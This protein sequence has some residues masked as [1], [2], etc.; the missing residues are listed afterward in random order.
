MADPQPTYNER[1]VQARQQILDRVRSGR[2]ERV[3]RGIARALAQVQQEAPSGPLT[4]ETARQLRQQYEATL[5]QLRS[6]LVAATEAQRSQA[7][8][9]TADAHE[10]ALIA[11]AIAAGLFGSEEEAREQVPPIGEWA[12][13]F[14][15]RIRINIQVR[16]GLSDDMEPEA[17]IT[18]ILS[19][20]GSEI[21]SAIGAATGESGGVEEAAQRTA[22]EVARDIG[23][24]I[25]DD[26]LSEA[27]DSVGLGALV[28]EKSS[29]DLQ[30]AKQ[31]GSNLRRVISHE[32]ASVADEAGKTLSALNPAVDLVRW[33]LSARHHTLAS[34]PDI[35][36]VLANADLYGY[37][38]GVYH[39]ATVPSL[40]HP[41]CECR[42][43]TILKPV[44]EWFSG[45]DRE[46]P[47]EP[48]VPDD[49]VRG[50]MDGMDGD[51]TVTEAHV[52]NQSDM[53]R[54]VLSAVHE[55][56]RGRSLDD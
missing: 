53:L 14:R 2:L 21:D 22:S 56:P 39:P 32:V 24:A 43:S 4:P 13:R 17:Y 49:D 47:H 30:G 37:G 15:E 42:Q 55:N 31:L 19:S 11:A 50:L 33:E 38:D 1:I 45:D 48:Y 41:H 23:A 51:R 34:S 26:D 40:P 8:Q 12:P 9:E 5:Q 27:L 46:I 52:V 44:S 18:R 36:D 28:D 20:V 16:R 25:A 29:F 7:V 6:D 35:C 10:E 3:R 54:R